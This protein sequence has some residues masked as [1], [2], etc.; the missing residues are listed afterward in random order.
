MRIVAI[1]D[2][3]ELHEAVALPPGDVLVHAGD[4]TGMGGMEALRKPAG[5]LKSRGFRHVVCIAGNHDWCFERAAD[6]GRARGI[7]VE[8]GI[9]YLQDSEA[10]VEGFNFYGSPWTPEFRNWA[11]NLPRGGNALKLCW[12]AIPED[13][14]VLITHGP[15]K[16]IGDLVPRG[17]L[18]GCEHL[19]ARIEKLPRLKV[20]IFG[21][22]HEGYGTYRSSDRPGF[23]YVNASTCTGN[24]RPT[25][26]PIVID[27]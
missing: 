12:S 1:S 16:G 11:F 4:L 23:S 24:Y 27:V 17:E 3:H 14:D 13:T 15:P 22:I 7:L 8:R 21:H 6:R 2:T 25:N 18:T 20:H 9:T 26:P 5:W 10:V 19:L